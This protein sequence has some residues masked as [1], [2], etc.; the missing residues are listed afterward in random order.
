MQAFFDVIL[1]IL[2]VAVIGLVVFGFIVSFFMEQPPEES[3]ME[4]G[5][6]ISAPF[7]PSDEEMD[8]IPER[9]PSCGAEISPYS[10]EWDSASGTAYCPDCKF[11]LKPR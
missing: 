5:P 7:R 2:V 11:P 1:V 4:W 6:T 10:V 9:C 3:P 8:S